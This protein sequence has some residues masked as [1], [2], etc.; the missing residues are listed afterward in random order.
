MHAR[1]RRPGNT[2][3]PPRAQFVSPTRA[4]VCIGLARDARAGEA[5]R[6][7]SER[8]P[9]STIPTS[10]D[11]IG[12]GSPDQWLSGLLSEGCALVNS[13][14]LLIGII[15]LLPILT[16]LYWKIAGFGCA[17]GN[18]RRQKRWRSIQRLSPTT[19]PGEVMM[20]LIFD[21]GLDRGFV[22]THCKAIYCEGC[23]LR[24]HRMCERCGS[25]RFEG[26]MLHA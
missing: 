26:V 3:T 25:E 2:P 17:G 15:L 8:K 1:A 19:N 24:S 5:P 20:G 9:L 10:S 21:P 11:R 6:T 7:Q 23:Y 14:I 22:C 16:L 4:S 13:L 12:A 18:C